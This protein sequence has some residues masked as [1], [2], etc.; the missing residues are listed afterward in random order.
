MGS[1]SQGLW[2]CWS[3]PQLSEGEVR[4]ASRRATC[5]KTSICKH[6]HINRQSRVPHS[7]HMHVFGLRKGNLVRT[8]Q[9]HS[10]QANYTQKGPRL[11]IE[12]T[13]SCASPGQFILCTF[14]LL[15]S[16]ANLHAKRK[17]PELQVKPCVSCG[18]VS[19]RPCC[20][21]PLIRC[22]STLILPSGRKPRSCCLFPVRT[23]M[24]VQ[25]GLRTTG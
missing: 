1:V 9:A 20:Q 11:V 17:C 6:T 24:P 22:E 25:L 21:K 13:T 19:C 15:D 14:V 23:M 4:A 5:I 3:L 16:S 7:P 12:P 18:C 2:V 10:E 8:Q